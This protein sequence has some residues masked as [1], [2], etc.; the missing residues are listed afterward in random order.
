[1][2]NFES[3]FKFESK[4]GIIKPQHLGIS[5]NRCLVTTPFDYVTD[6]LS[7]QA[8]PYTN[9]NFKSEV[10]INGESVKCSEY[11]W[12]VNLIERKG[13]CR[14][15]EVKSLTVI[16]PYKNAVIEEITV[17]NTSENELNIPL[18]LWYNG[19]TE[20]LQNWT[21]SIP[22]VTKT[23]AEEKIFDNNRLVFKNTDGASM[24]IT[25][26]IEFEHFELAK[27]LKTRVSFKPFEE[28]T[29]YFSFH[30]GHIDTVEKESLEILKDYEKHLDEA[31]TFA[32]NEEKR[33]LSSLPEFK[34]DNK[35]FEKFYYRSLVTLL[36]N[37]WEIPLFKLNPYYSTGG[38]TGGCMCSYLWDYAGPWN[39]HPLVDKKVTKEEIKAFLAVDLSSSYAIMP[40]DG[41]KNGPW[42]QINQEKIIALIYHYLKNTGDFAFLDEMAGEKSVIDWVKFHAYFGDN[43]E[44]EAN[45]IDYGVKGEDHLELRRG[46]PYHGIMPDL[47]MRRYKTYE[48]ASEI[49][50]LYGTPDTK[51]M[52]RA[53]LVAALTKERLWDKEKKWFKF[54]I[55]GVEDYRYT[56]QMF[57]F[58]DSKAADEEITEGLIS[59]LND[60]E[61]LSDFGLHSMSKLDIAYDQVDIDNGGGGICSLFVPVIL[62]QLYRIGKCEIAND[63][64]RRI[65]WWGERMPYLGDSL[66]AN[67]IAY[68]EDT[69]LQATI[70]SS[71]GAQMVIFGI[72]GVSCD[73]EGNI[74]INPVKNSPD[75]NMKLINMKLRDKIFSVHLYENNFTV[76]TKGETITKS[77]NEKVVIQK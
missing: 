29:F 42:Y 19:N 24:I 23:E 63:I 8:P 36:L 20:Y 52:E 35:L 45:L 1:M 40:V 6:L 53:K 27:I 56:V 47:N 34:S 76:E 10:K 11:T 15:F 32:E 51:L 26:S 65:L 70:G 33:L 25:S 74:I 54:I 12:R 43:L 66:A 28:K 55:D 75:K 48:R 77:Y 13:S 44:K 46:I 58:L 67:A 60:N 64:F 73:F 50:T 2:R 5:G 14:N 17:K 49:L 37:R 61:F 30:S 18:E 31:F 72:F 59:H 4:D 41:K 21:F 39:I 38:T 57:K 3:K 16:P 9:T 7:L 71:A 69:P 68:R 22:K 62:E